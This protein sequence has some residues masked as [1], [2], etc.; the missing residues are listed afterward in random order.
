M[1]RNLMV[2]AAVVAAGSSALALAAD[3]KQIPDEAPAAFRQ[4]IDCKAIADNSA[5]LAC[6]DRQV[7]ALETAKSSGDLVVTDRATVREARRGLFGFSLPSLKIFGIGNDKQDAGNDE[8]KEIET[9]ISAVRS[10]GYGQWRLTLP[11]GAVWEQTDTKRLVIDPK[12]GSKI[13]IRQAAMGSFMA[14]VDGQTAI[15]VRRV[16]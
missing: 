16:Q 15:R 1:M 9:T 13:R 8:V 10:F 14:N 5:R 12:S 4:L 2:M 11:D 6:Y 7:A 3:K